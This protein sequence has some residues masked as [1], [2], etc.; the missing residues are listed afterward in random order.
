MNDQI[1]LREQQREINDLIKTAE[2]LHSNSGGTAGELQHTEARMDRDWAMRLASQR[3]EIVK[4]EA[5]IEIVERLAEIHEILTKLAD[6][7]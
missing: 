2:N 1:H 6:E 4:A 7:D 5:Q 3:I